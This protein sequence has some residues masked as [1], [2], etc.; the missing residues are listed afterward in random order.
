MRWV[1]RFVNW[2][3]AKKAILL[4]REY[5]S[6]LDYKNALCKVYFHGHGHE[7][8]A[9]STINKQFSFELVLD[10]SLAD[11]VIF[12]TNVD[13]TLGLVGK[14]IYLLYGES[15]IY[16]KIHFNYLSEDFFD[17]NHVTV[18]SHHSSAKIFLN[19]ENKFIFIRSILYPLCSHWATADELKSINNERRKK[20]IVTI[21]SAL[22][23]TEGNENKRKYIQ[24][25]LSKNEVLDV[26]GRFNRAAFSIKKYK[27][28]CTF[29]YQVL[30]EYKYNLIIENS[31]NED[32]WITEKI[33]D[34]LICGCMPIYH[35]SRKVFDLLP[36]DWFYFLPDFEDESLNELNIFLRTDAYLTVANNRG[37]IAS[38]ITENFSAFSA[39][40]DI[41]NGRPLKF[42]IGDDGNLTRW[43]K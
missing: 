23:G 40:E 31:P 20:L 4:R 30:R 12:G 8:F 13:E 18:I 29:K 25:F 21:T 10:P 36:H 11:I 5:A 6:N 3:V 17:K 24:K 41:V 38:Y 7:W 42:D 14:N 15:E 9:I 27:G 22:S 35:G 16:S 26:Y 1:D 43:V 34:S 2:R 32:W 28:I 19:Q 33:F 37:K 39:I